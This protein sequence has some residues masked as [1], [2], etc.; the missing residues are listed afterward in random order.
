[1]AETQQ[2]IF[3]ML[4]NSTKATKAFEPSATEAARRTLHNASLAYLLTASSAFEDTAKT[5]YLESDNMTDMMGALSALSAKGGAVY[6]ELMEAFFNRYESD[7]IVIDKWF[8]LQ[9]RSTADDVLDK[10]KAL[11]KHKDFSYKNPNRARSLI[12]VFLHMEI[13]RISIRLSL[14]NFS[15]SR[16]SHWIS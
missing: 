2:N 8:A 13:L 10:V 5:H 11:L 16:F 3:E 6:D 15:L 7:Q 4:Y 1:M 9:A 14:M 12:G